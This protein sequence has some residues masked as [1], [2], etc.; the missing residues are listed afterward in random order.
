MYGFF[1]II[2]FF[3]NILICFL[4]SPGILLKFPDYYSHDSHEMYLVFP[5]YGYH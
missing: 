5:F 1:A 3:E 4:N 2:K